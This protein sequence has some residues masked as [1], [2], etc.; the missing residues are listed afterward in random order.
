[1][2]TLRA[3]D[4]LP[5]DNISW[6]ED[7][8]VQDEWWLLMV[9]IPVVLL[10][11]NFARRDKLANLNWRNPVIRDASVIISRR[12]PRHLG[13][14]LM[15]LLM[16]ALVY[17]AARPISVSTQE[18]EKALLIWVYDA[19]ES[20]STADVNKDGVLVSRLSAS[21]AALEESLETIPAEFHKILI[22]FA[23]SEEVQAGIPTLNN[24]ELLRQANSITQGERTATDYGLEKA[25]TVCQQFFSNQDN[26]PCE[27]LLLSDGE[28]N[29]R[30]QCR[31]RSEELVTA[32]EQK[33]I[34]VHTVSWGSQ[35]SEYRPNPQ[36]MADL[37]SLGNGQHL[38][39][40]DTSQLAELY[41]NVATSIEVKTI[42]QALALAYVWAARAMI[43]ILALAFL[44]RRLE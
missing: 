37:A 6:L 15:C 14:L 33:G 11:M 3:N 44:L 23:S 36:D 32:A 4:L 38:V 27:V 26:Y 43:I 18:Q 20:M 24:S 7:I 40:A 19:S 2:G 1:M 39:S 29:P 35:D 17:P 31:I 16:V 28:C 25:F 41:N 30:P 10:V 8:Q 34:R 22:S 12:W 42:Y 13:A 9:A 5:I 21:V